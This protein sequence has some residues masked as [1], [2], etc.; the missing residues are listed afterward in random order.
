MPI[1]SS[2]RISFSWAIL[3]GYRIRAQVAVALPPRPASVSAW[4]IGAATAFYDCANFCADCHASASTA[5]SR[6]ACGQCA[7]YHSDAPDYCC[8]PHHCCTSSYCV[9]DPVV[10]DFAYSYHTVSY[11]A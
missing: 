2:I 4:S 7:C 5:D 8:A 11:P 9:A 10:H 6:I 3:C 1:A